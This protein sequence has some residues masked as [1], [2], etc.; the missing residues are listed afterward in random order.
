MNGYG[1]R[2]T[3]AN[4]VQQVGVN[5]VTWLQG[6]NFFELAFAYVEVVVG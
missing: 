6:D 2:S 5:L 1:Q 3:N 4:Y